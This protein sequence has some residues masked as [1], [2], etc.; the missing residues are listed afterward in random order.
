MRWTTN[1]VHSLVLH[2]SLDEL[3]KVHGHNGASRIEWLADQTEGEQ[4]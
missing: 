1:G 2:A 3:L 4:A